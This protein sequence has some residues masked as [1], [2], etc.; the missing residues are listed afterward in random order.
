MLIWVGEKEGLKI[1]C[2]R[3]PKGEYPDEGSS[4][5][6][7]TNPDPNAY[8]ELELLAPLHTLNPGSEIEQKSIYTLYHRKPGMPVEGF[9]KE[10]LRSE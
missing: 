8:V 3:N 7:Y 5:E 1:E 10:I 4:A 9:R 2:P 6:V